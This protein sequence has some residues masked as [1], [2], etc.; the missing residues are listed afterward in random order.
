MIDC[1]GPDYVVACTAATEV[2]PAPV[3][4]FTAD[5]IVPAIKAV[6]QVIRNRVAD[7]RFPGTAVEVVL[8][9]NQFSAVCR[10]DYWVKAMAGLWEPMHV[11]RCI[12][13]WSSGEYLAVAPGFGA[14]WYYSP[15]SMVPKDSAP[16][17]AATRTEVVPPGNIDREYFRFYKD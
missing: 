7:A 4:T 16:A 6:C 14:L 9:K 8:Q 10:Q 1:N 12:D 5:M 2:P 3:G 13:V 15:A 17:W 11:Q